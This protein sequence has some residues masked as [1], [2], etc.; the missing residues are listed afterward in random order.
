[1]RDRVRELER[2]AAAL[3][4]GPDE[5]ATLLAEVAGHAERFLRIADLPAYVED[6]PAPD[7]PRDLDAP[8][9]E[10]PGPLTEALDVLAREVEPPGA[11]LQS[12]GHLGF[13]PGG[14]IYHAALGDYLADVSNKY[15][16]VH[17]GGP[18]AVRLERRVV[19][20]L[21]EA[22]GYPPGA[23]GDLTSG[24]SLANLIGIVTAREAKGV[25]SA[26][27][28]RSPV[29]RGAHAHHS[30]TKA[31]RVAGL[32]ECPDR[33]VAHDARYRLR[34]EA[35]DAA[36]RAD[37]ERGRRPWLVVAAAGATDT[38]AVDPLG[39]LADVCAAHDLWLHVDGAYGAAFALC[40][41]GRAALAGLERS[42]STTLDPHKGLFLPFG[43]GVALVRDESL[44]RRAHSYGAE[45]MRDTEVGA[46]GAE[47]PGIVSPADLSPEMSRP[48]R[49][50]RLWLPLKVLGLAPFRAAL[51][52]KMLLARILREEIAR[53]DGFEVGPEPDLSLFTFRGVPTRGD[54]DAWNG[55]LADAIRRDGRVLLT[56][57]EIDGAVWMRAAVLGYRTHLDTIDRVVEV[58]KE[59]AARLSEESGPAIRR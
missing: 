11:H 46:A 2:R 50:L 37:R 38:G 19:R 47:G 16:G 17:F 1:V 33:V 55:R 51:E 22:I 45:Y 25:R 13:I 56:S 5:R 7:A 18:G 53:L 4:P 40:E 48:F 35:L 15:S 49:G 30:V 21:V 54:P 20:W 29:Y 8:F 31:L 32:A 6:D 43:S 3:E 58:L 39:D 10:E 24:G 59:T 52:E 14:G 34:P 42:D 12:G 41:P 57:T 27:V 44:L 23:G 28:A 36:V 9:R 26:D